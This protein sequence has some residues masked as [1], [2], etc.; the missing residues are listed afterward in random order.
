MPLHQVANIALG[1]R[2]RGP[3]SLLAQPPPS[4]HRTLSPVPQRIVQPQG[5]GTQLGAS[6]PAAIASSPTPTS[7]ASLRSTSPPG[8]SPSI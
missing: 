6:S 3:A 5:K 1:M 4:F 7:C 8:W 2:R